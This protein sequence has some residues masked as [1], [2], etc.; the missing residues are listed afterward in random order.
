M[1]MDGE[2]VRLLKAD[3]FELV[4]KPRLSSV[5]FEQSKN[6]EATKNALWLDVRFPE[7]H[8]LSGLEGSSNHPLNTLRMHS[9]QLDPETTYI[10]Y[11][12]TGTCS[13]VAVFLLTER[14]FDVHCLSGGLMKYELLDRELGSTEG[15]A[16]ASALVD[17]SLS[18]D[19]SSTPEAAQLNGAP[20]PASHLSDPERDHSAPAFMSADEQVALAAE[21]L[22]REKETESARVQAA[23]AH[24]GRLQAEAEQVAQLKAEA[25]QAR[26]DVERAAMGRIRLEREQITAETEKAK[27]ELKEAH[28]EIACAKAAVEEEIRRERAA[29]QERVESIRAE[30]Q[31]RLEQ[32]RE[33]ARPEM[34]QERSHLAEA[35]RTQGEIEQAREA[36][37]RETEERQRQQL[38][39]ESRLRA[40]MQ[41]KV[42]S[43]REDLEQELARNAEEPARARHERDAA[44]AARAAAA[45][46]AE[47]IVQE[48]QVGHEKRREQEEKEMKAAR[49]RLEAESE[50]LRLAL[51]LAEREKQTALEQ[52]HDIEHEFAAL[53]AAQGVSGF[54]ELEADLTAL[55]QQA[56]AAKAH[57]EEVERAQA[58]V[59]ATA[60][61][62]AS[63][64]AA[65]KTHESETRAEL[66]EELK[67]WLDEQETR[68]S[69]DVQAGILANQRA[70]LDRI[71]K[72]A[73][74]A[75]QA[76]KA[77]D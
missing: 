71:K 62:I 56:S 11:S 1:A 40:E 54:L 75:R 64:L 32:E 2:L 41:H 69:D 31:R 43:E 37:A 73:A 9:G 23:A 36:S 52:Q 70:H 22:L 74:E 63:D 51:H 14:G 76:V 12:D 50:N 58:D 10:V 53:R 19:E 66:E 47:K 57:V 72:R 3:F 67:D 24:A 61:A 28:E 44:D 33:R 34:D 21:R 45:D 65:H 6:I 48:V 7:E 55:E 60:A 15:A 46:E 38:E 59:E 26:L 35:R 25:E 17:L 49:T 13:A 77:H 39:L 42:Q 68:E 5:T 27:K 30:M 16:K 8:Q 4:Q 18:D 29:Q 20:L